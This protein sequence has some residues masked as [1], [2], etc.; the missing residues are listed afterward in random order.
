MDAGATTIEQAMT[1][2]ED[3]D[4]YHVSLSTSPVVGGSPGIPTGSEVTVLRT[5]ELAFD[6]VIAAI[7]E[8]GVPYTIQTRAIGATAFRM[9]GD[10]WYPEYGTAAELLPLYLG[11]DDLGAFAPVLAGTRV[12]DELRNGRP[13]VHYRTTS[14]ASS[15]DPRLITIDTGTTF[16]ID[17]WVDATDGYLVSAEVRDSGTLAS[18]TAFEHTTRLDVTRIDDPSNAVVRPTLWSD[19][20]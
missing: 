20:H 5:P 11:P 14:S 16:A 4:S 15:L 7:D 17:L 6:A 3:L 13:T 12:G 8:G 19:T 18:G 2:L 10:G 9:A 1:L